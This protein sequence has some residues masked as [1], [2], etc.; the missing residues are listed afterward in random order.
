VSLLVGFDCFKHEEI[1]VELYGTFS[2]RRADDRMS[3]D[4]GLMDEASSSDLAPFKL[5]VHGTLPLRKSE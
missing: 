2:K 1:T 4:R 3:T 5:V